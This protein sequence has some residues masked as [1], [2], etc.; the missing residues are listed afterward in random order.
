MNQKKIDSIFSAINKEHQHRDISSGN[1]VNAD[2]FN[3]PE[4]KTKKFSL[5]ISKLVERANI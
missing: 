3:V 1:D 5:D 2:C 4:L